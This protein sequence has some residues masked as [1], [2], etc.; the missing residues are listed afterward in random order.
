[1]GDRPHVLKLSYHTKLCER[2]PYPSW[3]DSKAAQDVIQK[4][5]DKYVAE[6]DKAAAN[7]EAE[8]ME[9]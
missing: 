9:I 4:M 7:K 5:T 2:R 8:T 3:D 1:M 6:V